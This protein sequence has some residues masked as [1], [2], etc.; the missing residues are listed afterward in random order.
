MIY[1]TAPFLLFALAA[2]VHIDGFNFWA[3]YLSIMPK[4]FTKRQLHRS[5]IEMK[6]FNRA[7]NDLFSECAVALAICGISVHL[8]CNYVVIALLD[9]MSL[10]TYAIVFIILIS[11]MA[12]EAALAPAAAK[13]NMYSERFIAKMKTQKDKE[14]RRLGR[15]ME[16]LRIEFGSFYVVKRITFMEVLNVVFDNTVNILLAVEDVSKVG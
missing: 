7:S 8:A 10:M 14:V 16:T 3:W 12:G 15:S 9:K 11:F 13:M 1:G 4:E 6:L 2:I 5:F